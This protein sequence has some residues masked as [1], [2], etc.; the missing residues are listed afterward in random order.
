MLIREHYSP[1]FEEHEKVDF[2]ENF[3]GIAAIYFSKLPVFYWDI[4]GRDEFGGSEKYSHA[5]DDNDDFMLGQ[6]E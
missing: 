6:E 3:P 4:K 5:N 2:F 1:H